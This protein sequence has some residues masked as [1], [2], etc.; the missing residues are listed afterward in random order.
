MAS[1]STAMLRR[2]AQDCLCQAS[3]KHFQ[4][5]A[6]SPP[7]RNRGLGP[8]AVTVL[9]IPFARR[10]AATACAAVQSAAAFLRRWRSARFPAVGSRPALPGCLELYGLLVLPS[11]VHR[12][13]AHFLRYPSP[14]DG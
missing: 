3:A 7:L 13:A 14:L 10:P 5:C 8:L 6:E 9:P 12:L 2:A 4:Q 1:G 11:C